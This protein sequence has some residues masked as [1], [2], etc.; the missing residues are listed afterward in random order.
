MDAEKA[1]GLVVKLH[2]WRIAFAT[3]LFLVLF[4]LVAGYASNESKS[5]SEVVETSSYTLPSFSS[6]SSFVPSTTS[7][8]RNVYP[9]VHP[10]RLKEST[11]PYAMTKH[12]IEGYENTV[13][14]DGSLPVYYYANGTGS[15]RNKFLF[16]FQGGGWC[17]NERECY[18][19]AVYNAP[20]PPSSTKALPKRMSYPR[21]DTDGMGYLNYQKEKNPFLYNWNVVFVIYC[22]GGSFASDSEA[23]FNG[24]SLQFRGKRI[25][26]AVIQEVFKKHALAEASDVVISGC[27]AG[28][29]AVLMGIDQ[30]AKT[31]YQRNKG[32]NL[33]ALVDSGFFAEYSSGL[34]EYDNTEPQNVK[35]MKKMGAFDPINPATKSLDYAYA[36]KYVFRMMNMKH[37]INPDCIRDNLSVDGGSKCM[38]GET[39]GKYVQTPMFVLQ[40][41][42]DS[43]Q[44]QHVSGQRNNKEAVNRLGS[45]LQSSI[46]N[47]VNNSNARHGAHIDSCVHHCSTCSQSMLVWNNK[48][49]KEISERKAFEQ[50]FESTSIRDSWRPR[51]LQTPI[52]VLLDSPYPC[53]ECC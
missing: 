44:I 26:E 48:E 49:S 53:E 9:T 52:L 45:I 2:K 10:A 40:S 28:G 33:K 4:Y 11:K 43:W 14:M 6:P 24:Q 5:T 41:K 25:R 12:V 39:L 31:I 18:E 35:L 47:I 50:W 42:Y 37:G 13:C 36:L 19:A 20:W 23:N 38:F 34:T 30:I 16:H 46:V 27:S 3:L 22:D 29:L 8:S 1:H 51:E 15:G 17:Y 21:E 7:L 32:V